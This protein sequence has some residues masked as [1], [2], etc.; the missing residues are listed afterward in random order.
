MARPVGRLQEI[1][2]ASAREAENI[3][4]REQYVEWGL[5]R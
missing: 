3:I 4:E 2:E 1:T 5:D